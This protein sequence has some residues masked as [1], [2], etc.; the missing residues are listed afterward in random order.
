MAE[1]Q[2]PIETVSTPL[3]SHDICNHNRMLT[4]LYHHVKFYLDHKIKSKTLKYPACYIPVFM[5]HGIHGGQGK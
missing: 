4:I 1:L 5:S 3:S 2:N